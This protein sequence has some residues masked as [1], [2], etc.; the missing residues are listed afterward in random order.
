[1]ADRVV[2]RRADDRDV[3]GPGAE[4][5]RI[6]DPRQVHERRRP[7]VGRQV[8]VAEDLPLAVPA[9]EPGE[10]DRRRSGSVGSGFVG[11]LCHGSSGRRSRHST[12]SGRGRRRL[13]GGA[14][15]SHRAS[16][17]ARRGHPST[18][19]RRR[20]GRRYAWHD[21][22]GR[23]DR[24]T[25]RRL[26][27]RPRR[28]EVA[29]VRLDLAARRSTSRSSPRSPSWSARRSGRGVGRAR[30]AATAA[31]ADGGAG[32]SAVGRRRGRRP[33][34]PAAR[35]GDGAAR[36]RRR[37]PSTRRTSRSTSAS[38]RSASSTRSS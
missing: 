2:E 22:R 25:R 15:G 33:S 35:P 34:T 31:S 16:S 11:A 19:V 26:V 28:R 20:A 21:G 37:R 3:D 29:V 23:G 27:A 38:S 8:E 7:D 5:G 10:V 24:V 18:G 6:G 32:A 13:A 36:G 12:G 4:L 17:G 14:A 1:M 30:L 9:V